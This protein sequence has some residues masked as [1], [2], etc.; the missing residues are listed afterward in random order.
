MLK[1][2]GSTI[3]TAAM[4]SGCVAAWGDSYNVALRNSRSIVIGYDPAVI[5]LPRLLAVAQEH[6]DQYDDDALLDSTSSSNIGIKVNT[7][8]CVDRQS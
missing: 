6:C 4:L 8:I 7:Y 3:L 2:W 1:L 5:N